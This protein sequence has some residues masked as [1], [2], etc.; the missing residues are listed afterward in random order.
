M[1]LSPRNRA[2]MS[3]H[4]SIHRFLCRVRNL[5]PPVVHRYPTW[6]LPQVL[7]AFT[8]PPFEPLRTLSLR[9]LTLKAAFLVAITSTRHISEFAVLSIWPDLCVIHMDRVVLQFDP[10]FVPK[11]NSHFDWTQEVILPNFCTRSA[12]TLEHKWHTLDV[13][14]ALKIYISWT[15]PSRRS[16]ALFVS[17]QPTSLGSKVSS[18][19][20]GCWT[21]GCI[22][23]AYEV[24]AVPPPR[25][26]TAH[27]TRSAGTTAAWATQA[28][29]KEICQAATWTTPLPFIKH[30]QLDVFAS[31]EASFSRRVFQQV[32]LASRPPSSQASHP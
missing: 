7:Q 29:L 6:D 1:I 4:P 30:Y 20:I 3:H 5:R 9:Y 22:A 8:E 12:H 25:H 2:P 24:H 13:H 10:S 19:T 17:F 11:I 26:I 18:A 15:A 16:E 32:H 21:R 31:A 23:R 27:S 28:S 14:R